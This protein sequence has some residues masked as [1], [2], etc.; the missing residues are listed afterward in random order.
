MDKDLKSIIETGLSG[1]ELMSNP[2]LNKGTAFTYEERIRFDLH[3]LLPPVIETLE[4]QRVRAYE[5]YKRKG[6]DL[7]RHIFLRALQDTNET[8]FYAL[9]YR[10]IAEMAPI[11]YT[12][13]VAQG[14]INFSHIYRRPRG[15]FLSYPLADMMDEIIEN[16]PY[17]DV[18][19]IVVTD[20]ERVL[21]IGDQG[22]GGM[23][24][25][26]GKLSLYTLI[27][28]IDPQRTLPIVLDV[29]TNNADRLNDPEYVGWRHERITG[30]AYW[31]FVD[32]FVT[33]INRKLPN[34]LLQWEDF[35]K[36]H[37]RPILDRY[38]DSL[39][40]FN[41]D[42]QGTAAVTLGA[43]YKAMKITK[44]KF[45][46]QQVVIL[47]AGSAGTGIA[48]YI[49]EAMVTEGMDETEAR[50][51][52][53]LLDS[54]G[55]LHSV[56]TNLTPIQQKFAQPFE[57]VSGWRVNN[58]Q[59]KLAEIIKNISATILIG[60]SSQP[61]QF[62]EPIVKDMASKVERPII[63]PL[64]NPYD[65]AEAV[66]GDLIQWT[67]GRALVA[68]GTEFP[69]VTLKDRTINIAQCNNFYIFPAIGL[70]VRAS[71]AKRVTNRMMVAAA[72]ALGNIS[73]DSAD[74]TATELL[75]PIE[76]MRDVAIQIAVRVGLQA[77]QDG[78]AQIMSEQELRERVQQK[79]W[80]PQYLSYKLVRRGEENIS[81]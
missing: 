19:V 2:V 72:E 22:A 36:P 47:G 18:D 1:K 76:N 34:V 63:F 80:I 17:T 81:N 55:L 21:G 24:I 10:H 32:K 30:Q 31:D 65:R 8:L 52:F 77:Q 38:R 79:F 73:Q 42:I 75:P 48:E 74:K 53:F 4:Q 66:P 33:C 6:E 51:H 70:A 50:K 57:L 44:K 54:K 29:G 16:R 40:T 14:C 13:V 71:E 28:G 49:H 56:R 9:L 62:T 78:V 39:C 11:I 27:G 46:D 67:D 58:G 26:I 59:I 12:P 61:G 37:A 15:L 5:A 64:S 60:V 7:E 25:P 20:G 3:G 69:P 35:A 43:L 68:T 41:D 45:S 23:G